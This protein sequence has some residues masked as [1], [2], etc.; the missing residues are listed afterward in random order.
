MRTSRR[1]LLTC[2]VSLAVLAVTVGPPAVA[3]PAAAPTATPT[4][5]AAPATMT[6]RVLVFW[7]QSGPAVKAAVAAVRQQGKSLG[8]AV[9][10]TDDP[11]RFTTRQLARFRAVVL[12][13]TAGDVLSGPQQAAFEEYYGNGGGVVAVHDAIETE[14]GWAFLTEVL[15]ARATGRTDPQS[16]Q[17]RVA[18]RV[19]PSTEAL[20]EY[21]QRS[22]RWYN[23]DTNVR[24]QSH[25]LATVDEPSYS[26]GTMGTDHP[27][28]WCKDWKGGRSFYVAGGGTAAAYDDSRFT[29]HLGGAVLWATGTTD[30]D[31]GAT[32]VANYKQTA[33]TAQPNLN[34]PIGFDNLPD[35]RVIQTDRRGGVRLHDP[36]SNTTTVIATMDVYTHSEDGLYGP[37]IDPD[38][39]SNRW[40]Y[41]YYAPLNQ[42]APYPATTPTGAAPTTAADPSAWD[43]WKGYFQL[44]RF[45]FVDGTASLPPT[46]DMSSEQKILKVDNNRGACCHV[47]GDIDFDDSGNL[48]LVTGDDTPAGG[49]NSGG[50]SPHNDMLTNEAQTVRVNGAAGGTFT[51]TLGGQ[52]T[53]PLPYNATSAQTASALQALANVGPTGAVVTGNPVNTANQTV[54]FRGDWSER[55]VPQLVADGTGLTGTAPAVVVA[56]T[57]QGGWYNSPHV[58]ARRTS[59]N[60]N[61]LRGKILRIKVA[62]DGSYTVPA[63]NLFE[64]GTP[65][66]RPEIYAMGF[67]NPFRIQVDSN[68]VA[69]ITDY[70]PDS[71]TPQLFRGPQGTGRVQVVREPAN[72]GWP[73]CVQPDLPYYTWNF[74][75]STTLD[76]PPQTYDCDD[77]AKGPDNT[78]RWN[79]GLEQTPPVARSTIWYSFQD[80]NPAALPGT[81]CAATYTQDPPAQRCPQL[82]PELGVGGVGPH[83]A[84]PYEFDAGNANPTK[85]PEYWDGAFVF[86]EFTRDFLR[87]I[88]L[89][90][91]GNVLRINNTLPCGGVGSGQKFTCDNPMDVQFDEDGTLYLLTYGDGFFNINPD[92]G[93]YRFE[94]VKGQRAPDAVL[95][96]DPTSGAAPLT[97]QFS[98]EGSKDDDPADSISFAWD[99]DGNGSVDS[100][101]PEPTY[102]Y[103]TPGQYTARL[104]VTDSSG[105][106][107]SANTTITVG[108]TAPTVTVT[109]PVD[110]GTFAFGGRVGYSV[111]VADQEDGTV[112]CSRVAV[113]FV[114]GHDTHGHAQ[115][116]VQ[117]C[118]GVFQTDPDDASHGGNVFGVISASYTDNPQGAAPA[119]TTVSQ[120]QLR[121]RQQEVEHAVEQLGTTTAATNDEGGGLHRTSLGAADWIRLNGPFDLSGI[122]GVTM[123]TAGTV[124][125]VVNVRLGSPTGEVLTSFTV[126]A[127]GSATT[128]ASSTFPITPPSG[129][130]QIYLTFGTNN[131]FSLNWVRFEGQ[132][133]ALP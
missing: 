128:W 111:T 40:V 5:A 124:N 119:L 32:V 41:L 61:D 4:P 48:W 80:N 34:E 15:G 121:Q 44:S 131:A 42:D 24:G 21:W 83:G 70:S 10:A 108:N 87:E 86:G 12:T 19:H 63:G 66:T 50:F 11:G 72:Y 45:K 57:Q 84:A 115:D 98:S 90:R 43:A 9:E 46:L 28:A 71:Q 118:S 64:P 133:V 79:T 22:D 36:S 127:T 88:R 38:F 105:K 69:Y 113:T 92:A 106:T 77:P 37:A 7:R 85:F 74:N 91:Q 58:D 76:D 18:D 17:V 65:G 49:G 109:S 67:R 81:P 31:C 95:S 82:F 89:D 29:R 59:L 123:R 16:A 117:G 60:S 102:T 55:D 2:L 130:R 73:L 101:E 125:G 100:I 94:Y 122:N 51:L 30:G 14:P 23:F 96:A 129:S 107:G 114:L 126:P 3:A 20:P 78:S 6:P 53:A 120:I 99:F 47:A 26:G 33:V 13:G 93:M 116:T 25:V 75:T 62:A 112:D 1:N 35:G 27:V 110:N 97:V 68:D 8:F 52:T 56:T 132:G 103:M 54:A 104:T 39:A